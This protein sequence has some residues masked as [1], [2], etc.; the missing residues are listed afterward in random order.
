MDVIV[1]L[2]WIPEWG[3][4]EDLHISLKACSSNIKTLFPKRYIIL[5]FMCR[6]LVSFIIILGNG[7]LLSSVSDTGNYSVQKAS[8]TSKKEVKRILLTLKI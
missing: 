6:R 1:S 2:V 8:I 5:K 7:K 3:G 4:G